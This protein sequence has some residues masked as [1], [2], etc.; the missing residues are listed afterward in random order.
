[1]KKELIN[2]AYID[3]TNLYKGC[4]AEGFKIGYAKFRK[5]LEERHSVKI[6]YI[7]ISREAQNTQTLVWVE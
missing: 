1:M 6:A 4:E 3:N 5:Y 7:F 2:Y